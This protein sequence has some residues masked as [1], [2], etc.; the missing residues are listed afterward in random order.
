MECIV[1]F[2]VEA[3]NVS[4]VNENDTFLVASFKI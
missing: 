1:E 3:L 4:C 2:K